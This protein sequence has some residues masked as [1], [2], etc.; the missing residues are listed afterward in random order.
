MRSSGSFL[1]LAI[2]GLLAGCQDQQ[3][4]LAPIDAQFNASEEHQAVIIHKGETWWCGMLDGN[5][6]VVWPLYPVNIITHSHNGNAHHICHADGV[7]NP[8]GRAIVRE[9]PP[10]ALCGIVEGPGFEW[11]DP[12]DI[13]W[14]NDFRAVISASGHATLACHF[15]GNK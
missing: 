2:V 8:T 13:T 6:E 1:V 11:P 7:A 4:P 3:Q 15:N 5:G 9:A 14:T 12:E 10:G